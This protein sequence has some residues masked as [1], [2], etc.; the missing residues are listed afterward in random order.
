MHASP[1]PDSQ[2]SIPDRIRTAATEGLEVA[3]STDHEFIGSWQSGIDETGLGDWVATVPGCELTATVPEHMN[4]YPVEPRF[5]LDARGGYVRWYGLDI[6][7]IYALAR[8]RGAEIIALNHPGYLRR[9]DYD[10][11]T[12]EALLADPTVLGLE[13]DAALWSWNFDVIEYMNGH[14]NP[15]VDPASSKDTGYFDDWMSFLN[16]GHL[17][18]AVGTTDIH[19]YDIAGQPRTYFA[20]S[21]DEPREF[22]RDEFVASILAGRCV[23]SDGAFA[24]V[25]INGS[26][27]LGDLVTDVDGFVD[28]AVHIEAIPEIDV[29]HFLVFVNCD[30]ALK[31]GASDPTGVVKYDGTLVV[32]VAG[33]AHVVV[34]G[35]GANPFPRGLEQFDPAGVPRFTT[36]PIY[37]DADGNGVYDPQGGKTCTYDLAPPI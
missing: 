36:N 15:F 17:I 5:D 32:P 28:L 9:V 13:P 23:V 22:D 8:E 31:V 7:E 10:R 29:T 18:T 14:E 3:V 11:L 27:G 25:E 2:V 34:A 21:T 6:A 1:S 30:E 33:D 24:R 20:S 16:L 19:G 37:V 4:I 12:G 35:F 26:A